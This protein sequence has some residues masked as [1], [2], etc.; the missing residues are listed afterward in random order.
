MIQPSGFDDCNNLF[1]GGGGA[2][3]TKDPIAVAGCDNI[4]IGQM[5]LDQGVLGTKPA[6]SAVT[7]GEANIA[8]GSSALSALTTG[9]GN[10]AIGESPMLAL[11]TGN[12]NIGLGGYTLGSL[13]GGQYNI[14][15]GYNGMGQQASGSG[16]IGMGH[17][18][19]F[20]N[21]SGSNNTYLGEQAGLNS[22]ANKSGAVCVGYTT[23]NDAD[24]GIAIGYQAH[25]AGANSIALGKNATANNANQCNIGG[26][27]SDAVCLIFAGTT[28]PADNDLA[29]GQFALY[30]DSSNGASKLKI[31]GKSANGTVVTG[32]VSLS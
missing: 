19:G 32:S 28:A 18:C 5:S 14:A 16:N 21:V 12:N 26:T 17:A 13:N 20:G 6:L 2:S 31:K 23:Q 15:I 7:D 29:A 4:A 27:G 1:I 3:A 8:I 24:Y 25:A 9:N 11:Q 30:W 22:A 10:T